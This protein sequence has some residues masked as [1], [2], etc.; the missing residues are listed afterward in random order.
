MFDDLIDPDPPRPGLDTLATV[1]ERARRL[2]R[3]RD[4]ARVMGL[5]AVA[6]LLVGALAFVVDGDPDATSE[7]AESLDAGEEVIVDISAITNPTTPAEPTTETTAPTTATT[8]SPA[9]SGSLPVEQTTTTTSAATTTSTTTTV[10][11][12]NEP[13]P[14][15]AVG[16][17]MML[18]AAPALTERG[19][20]VDAAVSRQMIDM[21]PVF[22]QFRDQGLFGTAVVVHLGV[23]GPFSQQTLDAFLAT[24]DEV[25]NVILVTVKADRSWTAENN[26]LLRAA[27]REGDNKILLDWEV[28][29]ADCPGDCFYEDG[30]H[31]RPDG[32]QYYANLIAD[33]LGL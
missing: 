20:V 11:I 17:S 18:G 10:P 5:G 23:N 32:Q 16:D 15:L 24:M 33:I 28:L 21:I 27:D 13:V 25:P 12:P 31:L 1:T 14:F 8:V 29:S 2:R 7:I 9:A 19:L 22:E 3:R 4:T 6:G 26:A 30:I